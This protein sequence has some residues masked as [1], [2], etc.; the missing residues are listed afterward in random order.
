MQLVG[1]P[2]AFEQRWAQA[3]VLLLVAEEQKEAMVAHLDTEVLDE[4]MT[5][6]VA[7]M[8]VVGLEGEAAPKHNR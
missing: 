5:K 8:E 2:I 3:R 6:K 4:S 7:T 1:H